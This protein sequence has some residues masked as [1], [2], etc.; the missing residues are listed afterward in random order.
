MNSRREIATRINA[1]IAARKSTPVIKNHT[2]HTTAMMLEPR[3]SIPKIPPRTARP[4]FNLR[5]AARAPTSAMHA[6][7]TLNYSQTTRF[8]TKL[9]TSGFSRTS[10]S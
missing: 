3:A 2:P 9:F 1:R 6:N 8:G 10:W 5:I 4:K 7:T